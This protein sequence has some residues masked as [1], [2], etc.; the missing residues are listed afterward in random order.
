M[1]H[2]TR[3]RSFPRNHG[4]VCHA[5]EAIRGKNKILSDTK[6]SFAAVISLLLP[7]SRGLADAQSC[8]G[9][10]IRFWQ[11]G[12]G[13][14]GEWSFGPWEY[15]A[16]ES[17]RLAAYQVACQGYI[18]RHGEAWADSRYRAEDGYTSNG[19]IPNFGDGC[20]LTLW[21]EHSIYGRHT[22]YINTA[23]RRALVVMLSQIS[24]G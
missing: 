21:G 11:Y 4:L 17:Q 3:R 24:G 14:P 1:K 2:A 7:L 15:H 19:Y 22:A 23:L 18:A 10:R 5:T 13:Y 12:G 16:D 6:G 8:T 20:G 9:K